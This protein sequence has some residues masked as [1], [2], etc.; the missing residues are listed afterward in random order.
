MEKGGS[1]LIR[2]ARLVTPA[3]V[4]A[5]D[6]LIQ[7]GRIA[8]VGEVKNPGRAPDL[9][10]EGRYLAPG[11]LDLH[12]HG[13]AGADFMD[14]DPDAARA[15]ALFHAQHG[16]TGLLATIVPGPLDRMRRAMAAAAGVP[17]ILGIHLEGPFLNPEKA[18]ALDPGWFLPPGRD[19]FR[20]LVAGFEHEIKVV[21]FAPELPGALDLVAEIEA[22]G[23]VPAIGHTAATHQ[24]AEQAFQRGARHVTHLGNAMTGLHHRAP[25]CVGAAL[26]S[27]ASVELVCDGAHLHPVFVR[28]VVEF[29]RGRGE[30]HRLCLVTDA[31]A[32]AGMPDGNYRLGDREVCL[33]RGAVRLADGTLAGSALTLDQA[34]R[35]ATRSANLPLEDALVL[36]TASP[37]QV[38]G[39]DGVIGALAVGAR[40]DLVFLDP[41]LTVLTT[42]QSGEIAATGRQIKSR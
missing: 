8:A 33:E 23:A 6:C 25:G 19:A 13:G 36:V 40:A 10:A 4:R 9:D 26:L 35:N 38:L 1:L 14:G 31:T 22:I 30:L 41:D 39:L 24:G 11:F 32:A 3:G 5:G 21:T 29:L 17:G 12:V 20:E 18:G 15:V 16:T 28:L 42:F 7:D 27:A 37:A 2:N 34:L